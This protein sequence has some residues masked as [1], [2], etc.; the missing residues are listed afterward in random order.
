MVVLEFAV[1]HL[2]GMA[3]S[4]LPDRGRER[5]VSTG[6]GRITE[7]GP[8]IGAFRGSPDPC[9]FLTDVKQRGGPGSVFRKTVGGERIVLP[10]PRRRPELIVEWATHDLSAAQAHP[11][12]F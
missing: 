10:W 9:S 11:G 3:V 8:P 6:G 5:H 4:G 1:F 12:H 7:K 2:V